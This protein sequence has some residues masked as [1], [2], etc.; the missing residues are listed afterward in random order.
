MPGQTRA[1][2]DDNPK[3]FLEELRSGIL[4]KRVGQIALAVVLAQA[5][6]RLLN[7]LTWYLIIPLI[8]RALYGQTESVL[9]ENA[10]RN[11]F[12]WDTLAGALLEFMLTVIVVFYLNR[13][14]RKPPKAE[15]S[16]SSQAEEEAPLLE[17]VAPVAAVAI[18]DAAKPAIVRNSV[19]DP[20]NTVLMDIDTK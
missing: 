20:I 10:K 1:P 3:A 17:T 8:G 2:M 11:P 9:F 13:W 5:V 12:G 19:G 6:W 4:K 7:T 15:L 14:I 16:A 18:P